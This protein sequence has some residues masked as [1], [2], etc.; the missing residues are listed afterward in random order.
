MARPICSCGMVMHQNLGITA[1]LHC[2]TGPRQSILNCWACRTYHYAVDRRVNA[3]YQAEA[4]A[5][6]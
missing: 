2:D 4:N 6:S 1:C 3:E 5:Q